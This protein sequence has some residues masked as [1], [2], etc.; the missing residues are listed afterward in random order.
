LAYNNSS[1]PSRLGCEYVV[2]LSCWSFHV[3]TDGLER[4]SNQW[5][6]SFPRAQNEIMWNESRLNRYTRTVFRDTSSPSSYSLV[7]FFITL[8]TETR[9]PAAKQQH[10]LA[11]SNFSTTIRG[12]RIGFLADPESFSRVSNLWPRLLALAVD[13]MALCSPL[14]CNSEERHRGIPISILS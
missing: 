9:L 4:S 6:R 1:T 14:W 7:G 2:V 8:H 11:L 5:L 13:L 3:S 12:S 10:Q